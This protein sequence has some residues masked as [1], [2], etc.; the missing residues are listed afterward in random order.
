MRLCA[1][2]V[3]FD[4]A[5]G[6]QDPVLLLEA[7]LA[8]GNTLLFLGEFT[9]ARAH[10]E[11][12]IALYD[13]QRHRSQIFLHQGPDPGVFSLSRAAQTLWLLG[14]PVQALQRNQEAIILAREL[15][16]PWLLAWAIDYT[17][18][19]Y[20][21]CGERQ[22]SQ[23]KAEAVLALA[24][25]Q[26]FVPAVA[27]ATMLRGWSLAEQGQGE[28][29][30]VQIRQGQAVHQAMGTELARTYSL[31]LLAEACGKVG[32][33]EEGLRALDEAL[34]RIDK[35]G[36]RF[37][38]AELYRLKGELLL[39]QEIK[40]QK[41]N[42]KSQKSKITDPRPLTLNPQAE[43]EAERCFLK[44]IEIARKQQAKSLELRATMSLAR[45]WQPQGKHHAARNTLSEIYNWFTEGFDTKDLQEAKALLAELSH[46][47]IDSLS[48]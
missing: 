20:Q 37:Y 41:S 10:L 47:V 2:L 7:H 35:N 32:Q 26:G 33:V 8:L 22:L 16:H 23:K 45:L 13:S 31:A 9:L 42:G 19:T 24:S 14:Y 21:L 27:D 30:I 44:A 36:E 6:T 48:D 5:R 39:A 40:S 46:C 25:E 28:E 17:A 1:N 4:L 15:S 29:G 38:E 12:S 11:Q 18:L 34:E 43:V 3:W